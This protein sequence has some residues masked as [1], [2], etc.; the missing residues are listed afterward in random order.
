MLSQPC[1][2][3]PPCTAWPPL[4]TP[5]VAA[6]TPLETQLARLWAEDGR[7][8]FPFSWGLYLGESL[9]KQYESAEAPHENPFLKGH[10][11]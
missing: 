6:S 4:D 11:A 8:L 3:P 1:P 2:P 10:E 5:F 9:P 7:H